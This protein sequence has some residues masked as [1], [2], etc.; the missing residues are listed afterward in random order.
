MIIWVRP[1]GP[2]TPKPGTKL[3]VQLEQNVDGRPLHT[4][5]EATVYDGG[6]VVVK[7]TEA[8]Q[9]GRVAAELL[10]EGCL[11]AWYWGSAPRLRLRP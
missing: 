7:L 10:K 3:R 5:G 11:T 6:Q 2:Q 8:S 1:K 4:V 9:A